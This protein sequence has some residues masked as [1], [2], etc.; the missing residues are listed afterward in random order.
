[1]QTSIS[2]TNDPTSAGKLHGHVRLA[3]IAFIVVGSGL[4]GLS[5]E[6]AW[7]SALLLLL[8]L[9]AFIPS[10]IDGRARLPGDVTTWV[11]VA[12]IAWLAFTIPWSKTPFLSWY[13]FWIYATLP[14]GYCI[15]LLSRDEHLRQK[16][17]VVVLL[18]AAL[19]LS[20]H[21][22]VQAVL[23]GV[24]PTGPLSDANAYAGLL[25]AIFLPLAAHF[26]ARPFTP[27]VVLALGGGLYAALST[28][29]FLA[30]SRGALLAL[31]ILLPF[32]LW[33][34]R[35]CT[36]F[37]SKALVLFAS[38]LI[39]YSMASSLSVSGIAG[40]VAPS[41]LAQDKSLSTRVM[42][43]ASTWNMFVDSPL[44]GHGLGSFKE[45][46]PAYRDPREDHTAGLAAHN[47]YLQLAA[48]AGVPAVLLLVV[49]MLLGC[50]RMLCLAVRSC[51][52][53]MVESGGVWAS[54]LALGIHA[55]VNFIFF[56]PIL[57]LLM[58]VMLAQGTRSGVPRTA[59]I[60]RPRRAHH[61]AI[62]LF[63]WAAVLLLPARQL[64]VHGMSQLVFASGQNLSATIEAVLPRV[65]PYPLAA[66][67]SSVWRGAPI[68]IEFSIRV[69]EHLLRSGALQEE[70][71]RRLLLSTLQLYDHLHGITGL[72][73]DLISKEANLLME[74]RE[75][76]P[77]GEANSRAEAL[78]LENL[79]RN[80]FHTDS[81]IALSRLY[82]ADGRPGGMEILRAGLKEVFADYDQRL[83]E[84]E[85]ARQQLTPK[86]LNEAAMLERELRKLKSQ[87]ERGLL[88]TVSPETRQTLDTLWNEVRRAAGW[89]E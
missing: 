43:W 15:W 55:F 44:V 4:A 62:A 13:Q 74:Q 54:F 25:N 28:A 75:L 51:S 67:L 29:F 77:P 53:D 56:V 83:L 76:L 84:L 18:I 66:A 5:Y 23:E 46:Y 41:F 78:L 57:P 1:M 64:I 47:D 19:A 34:A 81:Y 88:K 40:R 20:F 36:G 69:N 2:V 49:P 35:K 59:V 9:S 12:W 89:R 26:L 70:A 16:L 33:T 45:I 38:L 32:L 31:I 65:R 37:R 60:S 80:R 24:R 39:G 79:R 61:R 68:P 58:G 50:A 27:P 22:I 11:L 72:N 17:L 6:G 7:V 52:V 87:A 63:L 86:T 42:M 3:F 71:R 48:E 21:G 8:G 14:G 10:L 30:S 85:L 82:F 73:A